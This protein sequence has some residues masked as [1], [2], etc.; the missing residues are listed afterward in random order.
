MDRNIF[1]STLPSR[2]EADSAAI[3]SRIP[4]LGLH[5]DTGDAYGCKDDYCVSGNVDSGISSMGCPSICDSGFGAFESDSDLQQTEK[6]IQRLTLSSHSDNKSDQ[7]TNID[8][9]CH[10]VDEGFIST[11]I[12]ATLSATPIPKD[13]FSE[14]EKIQQLWQLFAPDEEG[15]T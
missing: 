12:D 15:D 1:R 6:G 9:S 14:A 3:E 2:V 10:S 8:S 7:F 13:Q 4:T 5:M 11:E